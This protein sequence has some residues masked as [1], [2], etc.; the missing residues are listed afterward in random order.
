[1]RKLVVAGIVLFVV[2]GAISTTFGLLVLRPLPTI[3]ADERLLGLHERVEILRD[4]Y[5]VPHVFADDLHDVFFAQ[6]YVTAQDRL[7]QMDIYRRAAEGRLAEVLG[8][9]GLESDRFTRTLGLGR[10]AQLDLSVISNEARG[11]VE[12]YMEGVNKFLEQHGESL[13]VEFTILGYRPEPW[14]LVDTLGCAASGLAR[15]SGATSRCCPY[16]RAAWWPSRET[17]SSNGSSFRPSMPGF[18]SS[19][20]AVPWGPVP[21]ARRG[22]QAD[23]RPW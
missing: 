12:A 10:A 20:G 16:R 14:T 3:D 1:M 9:P 13:P 23:P 17:E 19:T 6:G 18:T 2:L 22:R 21:E 4:G 7:W 15:A 5:G 11:F 8:E